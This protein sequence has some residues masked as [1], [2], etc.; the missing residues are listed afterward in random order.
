ME[1]NKN[2]PKRGKFVLG[3]FTV[4]VMTVLCIFFSLTGCGSESDTEQETTTV[5]YIHL[6]MGPL[7]TE[8]EAPNI[9]TV[10][11]SKIMAAGRKAAYSEVYFEQNKE[12]IYRM[13]KEKIR[14]MYED[15]FYSFSFAHPNR[16]HL[17]DGK[18]CY[19]SARPIYYYDYGRN[20]IYPGR[21]VLPIFSE[22]LDYVWRATVDCMSGQVVV[23]LKPDLFG[24]GY[25]DEDFLFKKDEKFIWLAYDDTDDN[26]LIPYF[27][28]I[29][30][31]ENK[32]YSS[33]AKDE[34]NIEI[35]GDP[36]H[37]L[38]YMNMAFSYN[39]LTEESN[40]I[41]VDYEEKD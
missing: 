23:G 38:P 5:D 11:S 1:Q 21:F 31:S 35:E 32:V 14:D 13:A 28:A 2:T 8:T 34:Y 16:R 36:F 20:E 24:D 17:Y 25:S 18:G 41:W 29:L 4:S 39:E 15:E 22:N 37:A 33:Y 40:L 27:E 3:I 19:I 7:S 6:I 9:R 10:S 12:E 26:A 30:S